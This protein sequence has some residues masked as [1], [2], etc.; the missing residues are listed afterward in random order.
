VTTL[1]R[2][3]AAMLV[4]SVFAPGSLARAD[5]RRRQTA[6]ATPM[7]TGDV[8]S[9][10]RPGPGRQG[11]AGGRGAAQL[12]DPQSMGPNQ[13]DQFFDAYVLF[14]AQQ[15]LNLNDAQFL[16]FG[17]KMKN[18]QN[19]RRRVQKQR[20]DLLTALRQSLQ[21]EGALDEAAITEKLRGFDELSVQAGPEVRQAYSEIDKLLNPRQRIRFRLF[22]EQ[23]EQKKMDLLALARQYQQGRGGNPPPPPIVKK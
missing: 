3:V 9:Q 7:Q 11:R 21:A 12:P 8:P 13:V 1:A 22:E 4:L 20:H 23:M 17:Q 19:I 10:G 14:Q 18:L 6:P 16:T 5:A 15:F 2:A